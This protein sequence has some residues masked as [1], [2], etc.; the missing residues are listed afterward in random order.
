MQ[1]FQSVYY[2]GR[3]MLL[4]PNRRLYS[5]FDPANYVSEPTMQTL[6]CLVIRLHPIPTNAVR[7]WVRPKLWDQCRNDRSN[8]IISEPLHCVGRN[9]TPL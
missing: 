7:L 4:F 8:N 1:T 9:H 3:G 2:T 6:F 5:E